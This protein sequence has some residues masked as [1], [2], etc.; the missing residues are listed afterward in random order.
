MVDVISVACG[1][2]LWVAANLERSSVR[3]DAVVDSCH[4]LNPC[5]AL[6]ACKSRFDPDVVDE[7][8]TFTTAP[9][10]KVVAESRSTLLCGLLYKCRRHITW[11]PYVFVEKHWVLNCENSCLWLNT[12][13]VP[14]SIRNV[15][16]ASLHRN[17]ICAKCIK[18]K[19]TNFSGPLRFIV[20]NA[21]NYHKKFVQTSFAQKL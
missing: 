20:S 17:S 10:S 19:I 18:W 12:I 15:G 16:F 9:D 8:R 1:V 11:A 4:E 3:S 13:Q 14:H 2:V 7:H 21:V 6:V 5:F